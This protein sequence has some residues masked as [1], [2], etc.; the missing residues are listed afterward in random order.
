M[1]RDR[2]GHTYLF[3]GTDVDEL[4]S[5]A[6]T[7][8]KTL[9]CE[10][11]VR[12]ERGVAI[13]CC[14]AC[15]Q[16]RKI[17]NANH[18]DVHWLRPEMKSRIIGVEGVRELIREVNLKPTEA[19][20]KVAVLVGADRMNIQAANA[21]LKTLEEPPPRSVLVLLT[22]DPQRLLETII[23]RCLRLNFASEAMRPLSD[24]QREWLHDFAQ[25]ASTTKTGL[26]ARYKLL[27]TLVEHLAA[28]KEALTE[29]L[30]ARS[31]LNRYDDLEPDLKERLEDELTAS[32]EAEY[33]RQRGELLAA[34]QWWLRDVWL[35]TLG[36]AEEMLAYPP[37]SSA[38]NVVSRRIQPDQALKNL[39][40]IEQTQRMLGGTNVQEALALEVGL[41]KL[42]L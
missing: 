42:A 14:D 26:L 10:D 33:R 29:D 2:L 31:P 32:I 4:E 3:S 18:G 35:L 23:S 34:L 19:E 40:S 16:C 15:L 17:N 13:D 9:N 38:S 5:V 12:G 11:P 30:E 21:F 28:Q 6:R 37:L 25:M 22:A 27:G 1:E 39:E 7:L 8:A 24:A 36:S 20:Y 41:L